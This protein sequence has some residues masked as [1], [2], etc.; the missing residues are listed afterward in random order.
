M[1]NKEHKGVPMWVLTI[2]IIVVV[3]AVIVALL[4]RLMVGETTIEDNSEGYVV[5]QN[6][7][8]EKTGVNAIHPIFTYDNATN[9]TIKINV[10]F[11]SDKL[12]TISLSNTLSYETNEQAEESE[13]H[14]HAA[15]NKSFGSRYGADAFNAYYSAAKNNFT[16]TL[17]AS[18]EDLTSN[19]AAKYFM[20]NNKNG[21]VPVSQ[22]DVE[23]TLKENIK[24]IKCVNNK[25]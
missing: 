16:M 1:E 11:S 7:I 9:K 10:V 4:I 12:S 22:A 25:K 14:N 23:R 15:M 5:T 17:Y 13:A 20:L 19:D 2:L 18:A 3:V 8:C 21:R 24:D 6:I